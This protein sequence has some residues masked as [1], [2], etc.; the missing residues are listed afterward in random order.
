MNEV[1]DIMVKNIGEL[2]VESKATPKN[3]ESVLRSSFGLFTSGIYR[4]TL[5]SKYKNYINLC[6]KM[7]SWPWTLLRLRPIEEILGRPVSSF[8]SMSDELVERGERLDLLVDK[9]ETLSASAV[10]FRTASTNLHRK[11]W[12]DKNFA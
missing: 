11:M 1:K 8:Y 5:F 12:L 9:T 3:A 4:K 10:T 7:N 6:Q 2:L